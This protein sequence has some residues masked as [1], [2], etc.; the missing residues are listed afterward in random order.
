VGRYGLDACD[1]GCGLVTGSCEHCN[2]S[3]DS[4]KEGEFP[5]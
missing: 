5:D 3:M 4:I 2:E 1:S